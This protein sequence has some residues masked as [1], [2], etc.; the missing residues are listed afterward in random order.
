M[1]PRAGARRA[2]G[3]R[4]MTS[5]RSGFGLPR[6]GAG[7]RLAGGG[8]RPDPD[9]VRPGRAALIDRYT[10]GRPRYGREARGPL[11]G[12]TL[13]IGGDP[14]EDSRGRGGS[15]VAHVQ[16]RDRALR[17]DLGP[18]RTPDRGVVPP[19][20]RR[21]AVRCRWWKDRGRGGRNAAA[22]GH[23]RGRGIAEIAGVVTRRALRT[24][25]ERLLPERTRPGGLRGA[26]DVDGCWPG[27]CG[28]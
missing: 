14:E 15:S 6:R 21:T 13:R 25:A 12:G 24:A 8:A 17:G 3:A 20:R 23:G 10:R 19:K 4:R 16:R 22:R 11:C 18:G 1:G 5:E 26:R 7:L 27:A 2:G 9:G 28:S